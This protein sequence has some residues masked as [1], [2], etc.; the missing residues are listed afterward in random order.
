MI[1]EKDIEEHNG[2]YGGKWHITSLDGFDLPEG[3]EYLN[4]SWEGND[5]N[6][7]YR[8]LPILVV[9]CLPLDRSIEKLNSLFEWRYEIFKLEMNNCTEAKAELLF[10]GVAIRKAI[11]LNIHGCVLTFSM[12]RDIV[13]EV[14]HENT[15]LNLSG[16]I[17][18]KSDND[19]I[20]L[21]ELERFSEKKWHEDIKILNLENCNFSD[22][23]KNLLRNKLKSYPLQ[24]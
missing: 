24:L 9:S 19:N 3:I 17:F 5:D 12:I 15:I 14:C 10:K 1:E 6:G 23:E 13:K 11:E 4:N 21:D 22:E 2:V 18:K 8:Y 16:N 7:H 20:Y